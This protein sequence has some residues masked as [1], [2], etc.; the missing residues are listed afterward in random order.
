MKL[1]AHIVKKYKGF[2]LDAAF[3]FSGNRAAILGASGSGKTMTLRA[4]AGIL[5]PDAGRISY[6]MSGGEKRGAEGRHARGGSPAAE[7]I[8]YDSDRNI[9]VKPR[10]RH[11][12]YMF[13]SYAL[14]PTMTVEE[15]IA[16]G[17]RKREEKK[18]LVSELME[19]FD[20]AAL[21]N[22][23]PKELSGGQQQRVALAR[24][25][26]SSPDILLLDEPFSALDSS[27]RDTVEREMEDF[28]ETYE[29]LLI[30]VTHN[31]D[32]AFRL[33]KEVAVIDRGRVV[34]CGG[35][36]EVF[37]HPVT[38][39]A[40]KLSGCKNFSKAVN[41]G[42]KEYDFTDWGIRIIL[43]ENPQPFDT[44]GY[45][46]HDF[47]PVWDPADTRAG[48][49]VRVRRISE[50]E[51][52]RQVYIEGENGTVITWSVQRDL[53]ARI[54]RDGMPVKLCIDPKK[55]LFLNEK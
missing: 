12:G 32:E 43:E 52:E 25:V 2:G 10:D 38:V 14:F 48:I 45:R 21:A 20:V 40:A 23:K 1:C 22:R 5:T 8:L 6:E 7:R 17:I 46:A 31:R 18:R 37:S 51:F 55:L 41:A 19:R 33:A 28:L 16:C 30:L 11:V 53:M 50:T 42:G 27:V 24:I 26:A 13:Q 49:P 34:A 4:I 47:I 9:N 35:R 44:V 15:N 3:T 29:G 39:A 54:E 36:D